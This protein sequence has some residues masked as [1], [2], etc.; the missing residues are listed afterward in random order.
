MLRQQVRS[1]ARIHGIITHGGRAA[2]VIPDYTRAEFYVRSRDTAYLRELAT[3]VIACARGAAK[4]TGA[5]L[6]VSSEGHL[7]LPIRPND[8]LARVYEDSLRRL[9]QTVD[10]LPP[11]AGYGSTDFGNVSQAVPALHGY[12]RI[13]DTELRP[14]STEFAAA[15][16]TPRALDGMVTAAKAMAL[17]ACALV[18]DPALLQSARA[19]WQNR[20]DP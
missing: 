12:F 11:E 5:R 8:V 16:R 18:N 10:A 1:E 13:V 17:T 6:K 9:G 2:N 15:C 4:A 3:K 14:H 19:E 20:H 7:F